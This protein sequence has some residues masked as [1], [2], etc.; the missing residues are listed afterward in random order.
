MEDR[1]EALKDYVDV[2]GIFGE[3]NFVGNSYA[4]DYAYV[5]KKVA[6]KIKEIDTDAKI[7]IATALID[8]GWTERLLKA[9]VG[10]VVDIIGVHIYKEQGINYTCLKCLEI[11]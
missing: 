11:S 1:V 9:G 2:W 6:D 10:D 5:I 7:N 8:F 4:E 3:I